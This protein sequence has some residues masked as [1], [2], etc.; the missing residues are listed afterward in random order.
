M[1]KLIL[2]SITIFLLGKE[3]IKAQDLHFPGY[4]PSLSVSYAINK[5]TDINFLTAFK[6]RE[7]HYTV[8]SVP[9]NP[10]LLEI[11]SQLLATYKLNSHCQNWRWLR[12]PA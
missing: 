7:G 5:K 3:N 1:K 8:K 10:L 12:F 11:Y 4:T 9:Y 2:A 6:V